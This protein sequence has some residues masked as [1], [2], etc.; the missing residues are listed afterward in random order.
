MSAPAQMDF[1]W[2]PLAD[3][4]YYC[5]ILTFNKPVHRT[6]GWFEGGGFNDGLSVMAWEVVAVLALIVMTCSFSQILERGITTVPQFL[7]LR[8]DRFTQSM[9]NFIFLIAYA[10]L[11]LP[12]I[13]YSGA[14]GLSH[15]MDLQALTGIDEPVSLFGNVIAPETI[16][17]WLTVLVI[18][19]LGL[20][21]SRFGGLRTL[22]VLD[23]INGVG[24]LVGGMTIAYF[25]LNKVSGGEGIIEGWSIL[26]EAAHE[27][28]RRSE[29]ATKVFL[30]RPYLQVLP[31]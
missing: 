26:C 19:V 18:G 20:L 1:S 12:I 2:W 10:F 16:I 9:A 5:G 15:M 28:R 21:Y 8:Y 3:F 31:C 13:L 7:E 22:A 29:R 6:N 27:R 11:L 17:L 14:V 23:T 30:S 25:A 24:L 4:P